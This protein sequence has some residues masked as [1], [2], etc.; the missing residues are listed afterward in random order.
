MSTMTEG[1]RETVEIAS[2]VHMP[3]LGLGTY[4]AD[5]GSEVERAVNVAL[6]LGYRNI[7]TASMYGNERGIGRAL[8]ESDVPREEVFISTKVWNDE[9][10][11]DNTKEAMRGSLERLGTDHVDLYLVH[12]PVAELMEETWRAME[13]LL[14]EGK[15]RAIGV[16]NFLEHHLD[17]LFDIGN[18]PPAVDQ[19]EHQP[20]LPQPGLR[21]Y[22]AAH[23]VQM[24]AWAPI[25]R[26]EV[27][28][29]PELVEI[30][31]RYDK[32]A[33]QVTLRWILQHGVVTIP[34]SVHADRIEQ[35]A[36]IFDF[37]LSD[38]E[39]AIV[40]GLDEGERIG[41]HPDRFTG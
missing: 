2:G 22:C 28:D 7:D 1:L 29:I 4:K 23:D 13:E 27:L 37:E 15:T 16:C 19:V 6:D 38:E 18:V 11:Y 20:R 34:K 12:W 3:R 8:A 30:G 41:P 26:G 14:E 25:M 35:N 21:D 5:E 39:M 9:Q 31:E 17:R 33:V 40:D 10:G 24:Q 36:D 32:T